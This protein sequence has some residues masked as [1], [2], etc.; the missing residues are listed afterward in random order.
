MPPLY[1]PKRGVTGEVNYTTRRDI[2][3]R[4]LTFVRGDGKSKVEDI[5]G[6]GK[7]RLHCAGQFQLGQV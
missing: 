6:V 2:E 4:Q 1:M 7:G 3:A 5:T